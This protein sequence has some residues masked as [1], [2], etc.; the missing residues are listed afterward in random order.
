[1][2]SPA[3]E[4]PSGRNLWLVSKRRPRMTSFSMSQR[5]RLDDST[6][7]AYRWLLESVSIAT[8]VRLLPKWCRRVIEHRLTG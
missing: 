1:M 6:E 7:R 3:S 4:S 2:N 8:I 5:T